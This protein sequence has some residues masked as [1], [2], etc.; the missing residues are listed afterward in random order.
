MNKIGSTLFVT[1]MLGVLC[2]FLGM[3]LANPMKEVVEEATHTSFFNCSNSTITNQD[4]SVCTQ[5]DMYLPMFVGVIFGI[6]GAIIGRLA[7]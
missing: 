4:K 1:L 2:F 3:A 7:L 5:T 6:G